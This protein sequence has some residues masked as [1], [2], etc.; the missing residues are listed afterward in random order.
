MNARGFAWRLASL[1]RKLEWELDTAKATLAR[2]L[3]A[4]EAARSAQ[5]RAEQL[6][7]QG[8]VEARNARAAHADPRAYRHVLGYLVGL[9][10][11]VTVAATKAQA[12]SDQLAAARQDVVHRQRRLDV[13]LHARKNALAAYLKAEAHREEKEADAGWLALRALRRQAEERA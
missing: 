5:A 3:A 6:L 2:E 12:A 4:E 13:L 7:Q 1:Q 11:Q 9:G 8:A 10:D